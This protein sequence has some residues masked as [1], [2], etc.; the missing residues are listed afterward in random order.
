MAKEIE[1][2]FLVAGDGWRVAIEKSSSI[3]QFYLAAAPDRTVRVRIR[4]GAAWL[5]LKFGGQAR[6]RDE[7]EYPIPLTEAEEMRAFAIGTVIEKT[8][9]NVRFGAHVYEVDV[10]AGVLSGSYL[11]NWKRPRTSPTPSFPIGSAGK[12]PGKAPT[13]THRSLSTASRRICGELSH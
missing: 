7:F 12:L 6:V 11:R 2:K 9:H 4:D 13:T 3:R 10:F 1:R 8:R 5:T